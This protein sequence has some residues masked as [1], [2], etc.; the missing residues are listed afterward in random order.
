MCQNFGEVERHELELLCH[1]HTCVVLNV[2]SQN[3]GEVERHELELGNV[4]MVDGLL[5]PAVRDAK[6]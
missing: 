3:F 4:S 5:T 2:V 1:R 6:P